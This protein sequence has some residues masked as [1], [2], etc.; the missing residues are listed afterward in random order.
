MTLHMDKK[1]G[2]TKPKMLDRWRDSTMIFSRMGQLMGSCT[3]LRNSKPDVLV[4]NCEYSSGDGDLF[5][6]SDSNM[7]AKEVNLSENFW[8]YL[9]KKTTAR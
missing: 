5:L 6:D 9:E 2:N 7:G 4:R 8:Q 1:Q 3:V